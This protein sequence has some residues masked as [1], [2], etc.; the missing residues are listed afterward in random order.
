MFSMP[1]TKAEVAAAMKQTNDECDSVFNSLTDADLT[2]MVHRR[3]RRAAARV[4]CA[5]GSGA[6]AL[7]G[8]LRIHGGLSAVEGS[9][10]AVERPQRKITR[11]GKCSGALLEDD[12]QNHRLWACAPVISRLVHIE[13]Y[14]R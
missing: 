9:R 3:P 10:T 8:S 4:R 13:L 2:K 11:P 14:D 7:A 5:G 1:P 6:R 12:A